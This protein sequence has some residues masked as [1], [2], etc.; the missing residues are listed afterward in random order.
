MII[1]FNKYNG[2]SASGVTP[3]QVQEQI[4]S[5][6]TP[7]WDSGETVDYVDEAISGITPSD[8]TILKGVQEF[9]SAAT[10]GDVQSK[11]TFTPGLPD[12]VTFATGNTYG[13]NLDQFGGT[14][15]IP[16]GFAAGVTED[17]PIYLM[18]LESGLD[19]DV[20]RIFAYENEWRPGGV[21][22]IIRNEEDN[23]DLQ[24][25]MG[26]GSDDAGTNDF[27]IGGGDNDITANYLYTET[28]GTSLDVEFY[29]AYDY[30]EDQPYP[31]P[32]FDV[33][34]S[35]ADYGVYV[36]TENGWVEVGAGGGS[37]SGETVIELTQAQYD[38]LSGYAEN[39]TY[40]ITDAQAIIMDNYAD[41]D[42]VTSALTEIAASLSG[43]AEAENIQ[44]SDTGLDIPTWNSQGVITGNGT[45]LYLNYLRINGSNRAWYAN[46]SDENISF[47]APTENGQPG[48]PLLANGSFNSPVWGTYKFVFITQSEYDQLATKDATTIYFIIG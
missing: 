16:V 44:A 17:N 6:L 41:K 10:Y 47:V 39:T 12:G 15:S 9:S 29:A 31:D 13:D 3:E 45:R 38:A 19:G 34:E 27:N 11:Y 1:D 18:S 8:P 46:T 24:I 30:G 2:G 23:V 32:V 37:A 26:P 43:K 4:T 21:I 42:Y 5:A 33:P 25:N 20:G 35:S 48:Q 36:K 22:L 40:I 14:L 28:T 7:Y